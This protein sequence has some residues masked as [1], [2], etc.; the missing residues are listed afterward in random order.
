MT[1]EAYAGC[2]CRQWATL[3]V[4]VLAV[5]AMAGCTTTEKAGVLRDRPA[6]RTSQRFPMH[7]AADRK[8]GE[9]YRPGGPAD[10]AITPGALTNYSMSRLLVSVG[11]AEQAEFLLTR[12]LRQDPAFLPAYCD[13]ASLEVRKGRIEEAERYLEAGLR[14]EPGDAVLNNNLGVC[15]LLAGRYEPALER[16]TRASV[17]RPAS[18][19]FVANRAL[20]MGLMMRD[21]ES[22]GLYEQIMT[23]EQARHNLEV[24]SRLRAGLEDSALMGPV[25]TQ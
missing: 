25:A 9:V 7:V 20:A 1:S 21:A 8:A 3:A 17:A 19:R 2:G 10:R 18:E 24:I 6:W 11:K 14:R 23:A 13:L 5:A 15:L 12:V 22:F 16:F 4:V